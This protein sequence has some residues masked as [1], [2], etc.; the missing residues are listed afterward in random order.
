ML[1]I[2]E[3]S[4]DSTYLSAARELLLGLVCQTAATGASSMRLE[5]AVAKGRAVRLFSQPDDERRM[6]Q[7]S[8]QIDRVMDCM[9]QAEVA[10]EPGVL[11]LLNLPGC[12]FSLLTP[13]GGP[14]CDASLVR[15]VLE[16]R[17]TVALEMVLLPS[18]SAAV[19]SVPTPLLRLQGEFDF[20][21]GGLPDQ[22]AIAAWNNAKLARGQGVRLLVR[23]GESALSTIATP[24]LLHQEQPTDVRACMC[25]AVPLE[26][27][28][29]VGPAFSS[30]SPAGAQHGR[31]AARCPLSQ[32]ELDERDVQLIGNVGH[33]V[34]RGS[35]ARAASVAR[36]D[37]APAT[38]AGGG[39]GGG[40]GGEGGT[41][42]G[43]GGGGGGGRPPPQMELLVETRVRL[44]D[45]DL[46]LIFGYP[47]ALSPASGGG[48]DDGARTVRCLAAALHGAGEALVCRVAHG[49]RRGFDAAPKLP[50]NVRTLL[51]SRFVLIAQRGARGQHDALL[52]KGLATAAQLVPPPP[53]SLSELHDDGASDGGAAAAAAAA[54]A[55][56]LE[57]TPCVD[58]FNPLFHCRGGGSAQVLA[59]VATAAAAS[60]SSSS[61]SMHHAAP[62]QQPHHHH[63]APSHHAPPSHAPP[64]H[65]YAP[66]GQGGWPAGRPPAGPS[67]PTPPTGY[68]PPGHDLWAPSPSAQHHQ[69]HPHQHPHPQ[70]PPQSHP[71]WRPPPQQPPPPHPPPQQRP[72]QQRPPLQAVQPPHP[73]NALARG[74]DFQAASAAMPPQPQQHMPPQQHGGRAAAPPPPATS[75]LKPK[76]KM[77]RISLNG[78]ASVE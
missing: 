51:Q 26:S 42:G 76:K 44:A 21:V 4:R 74:C 36:A 19:S 46:G 47:W 41:D 43:G 77:Q 22:P 14:S 73:H 13:A 1:V 30:A 70:T 35:L 49:T 31:G 68:V 61:S 37:F 53:P 60:S 6:L 8:T 25:H 64:P 71:T 38:D 72:P 7:W 58:G 59:L 10:A 67:M 57:A 65:G 24:T 48:D 45:V 23:F 69:Q 15:S 32:L 3:T 18:D 16:A 9:R 5:I 52:L 34:T 54:A 50:P 56:L 62:P 55:R 17:A 27:G 78:G 39:G 63:H 66:R 75:N 2:V 11:S 33:F 40:G 20:S 12:A 28:R 29:G